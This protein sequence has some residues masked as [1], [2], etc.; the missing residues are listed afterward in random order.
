M[1]HF[2][3]LNTIPSNHRQRTGTNAPNK[4]PRHD[5]RAR[6]KSENLTN[7][8]MSRRLFGLSL[9]CSFALPAPAM[10]RARVLRDLA[11][12]PAPRQ[13][14]DIYLPAAPQN[15]PVLIMVHGGGWAIGDKS[16][17]AVW[18]EKQ[19]H[20][21]KK[22]WIF[23]S[24]NYRM[25]PEANPLEQ[26][27]DVARA[28]AYVQGNISGYNGDPTRI[29]VMGHSAGA[30]LVSLLAADPGL[31]AR[32]G[33]GRWRATVS[34]DTAAYDVENIMNSSPSRLYRN[35]FGADPI[36][37]RATSPMARL[38]PGAPDFLLVCSTRRANACPAARAFAMAL[39]QVGTGAL[40]LPVDLSHGQVNS[41]LGRAGRYTTAVDR[42]LQPLI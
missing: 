36:L 41:S 27:R 17:K 19:R 32:E 4:E 30:H 5:F 10:A 26:A 3:S 31:A 35:A 6:P 8:L 2:S 25:V 40:I 16:H 33:A 39:T 7:T 23:A 11:Y 29:V 28:I 14:L 18:R 37:W 42:F 15:A 1:P 22:G 34:L 24:V 9:A 13:T 21:G 38:E 12:G 20:W